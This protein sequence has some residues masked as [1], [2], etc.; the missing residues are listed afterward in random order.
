MIEL[1]PD[2]SKISYC[3]KEGNKLLR[4][5]YR[6]AHPR[7]PIPG[8]LSQNGFLLQNLGEEFSEDDQNL[9]NELLTS[10]MFRPCETEIEESDD[11]LFSR[12]DDYSLVN[13]TEKQGVE[14]MIFSPNGGSDFVNVQRHLAHG[15]EGRF[16][17][18]L[19][20]Q[21]AKVQNE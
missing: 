7:S 17:L 16:I 21:S 18:Q 10:P 11:F 8:M 14:K 5:I 19:I 6:K 9:Q 15:E 12:V 3:N 2:S 4:S 13:L 20:D 1:T